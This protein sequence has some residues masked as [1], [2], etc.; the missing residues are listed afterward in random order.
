MRPSRL[1]VAGLLVAS[2]G[3]AACGDAGSGGRCTPRASSTI[4]VVTSGHLTATVDR[5]VI[6]SGGSLLASVRV[7]GP[8]TYPAPCAGP[9]RMIVADSSDIHVDALAPPAPKGTPCGST[10]TLAAGQHVEYDVQ[11]TADPTLPTGTYRLILALD[12]LPELVVPVQLGLD[13][14]GGC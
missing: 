10:V 14:S 5:E 12:G 1:L 3:L 2:L 8:L 9:V 13:L 4:P 7:T 11:W 6:G